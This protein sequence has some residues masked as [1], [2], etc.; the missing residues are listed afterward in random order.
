M[1][2]KTS[3]LIG[4]ALDWAVAKC[5]GYDCQFDDEVT[6]PWLIPQEGYL[7]DEKP[8]TRYTPSTSWAQ[9]GPIGDREQISVWVSAFPNK[10][11]WCAAPAEFTSS[12]YDTFEKVMGE[13]PDPIHGPTR[14][15]AT[16]RCYVT[17][18]L[19]DEVEIPERLLK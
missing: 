14:L 18:N 7:H 11:L 10:G 6:G 12:T 3:E 1:K 8:L 2:V 4:Q 15:I 9:G 13:M 17:Y 19:G 5:E 16:M